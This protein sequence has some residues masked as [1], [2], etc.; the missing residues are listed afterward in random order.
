MAQA[1]H[2]VHVNVFMSPPGRRSSTAWT[3]LNMAV[4]A[5][6]PTA[7]SVVPTY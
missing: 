7:T 2:S 6:M 5:P 3:M 1:I 4:F